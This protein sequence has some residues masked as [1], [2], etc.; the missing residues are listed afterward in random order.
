MGESHEKDSMMLPLLLTLRHEE[1]I[2]DHIVVRSDCVTRFIL[3]FQVC[4]V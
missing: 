3:I 1:Q 2:I 4:R